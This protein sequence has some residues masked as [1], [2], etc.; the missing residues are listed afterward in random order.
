MPTTISQ[1]TANSILTRLKK[2]YPRARIAL[3]FSNN[4]ELLVS[5]ILS[6]QST[7]KQ[8][9]KITP[10]LFNKYKTVHDYAKA[11]VKE[12]EKDIYSSGF[13]RN[14]AKNIIAAAKII[15]EKFNGEVPDTMEELITLPGVARKTANIILGNAFNKVEG[16]AVDTHVIRL[17]NRLGFSDQ[18]NPVKIEKDLMNLFERKDWFKLTYVLIDHGRAICD[19]KKPKCDKCFLNDLCPSAYKFTQFGRE[20]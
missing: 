12:F 17:S 5:V 6:A 14:K 13:Y 1:N 8:I 19:A 2:Q 4:W 10:A 11:N 7:D 3:N 16:I 15:V 20:V 9:N 18:K